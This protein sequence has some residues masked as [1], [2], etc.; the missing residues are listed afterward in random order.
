MHKLRKDA[1]WYT[2]WRKEYGA[3][4]WSSRSTLQGSN[5][6]LS[7]KNQD[8]LDS[9][10]DQWFGC[11]RK[12]KPKT[13]TQLGLVDDH[14]INILWFRP[15]KLLELKNNL[16]VFFSQ[17]IQFLE[18]KGKKDGSLKPSSILYNGPYYLKSLTNLVEWSEV[19]RLYD[20]E[21]VYISVPNPT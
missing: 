20:H 16:W 18:I 3:V 15:E 4:F 5:T 2:E 21:N 12:G 1:K 14:T 11:L 19:K 7:H 17:L 8:A 10:F 13:L 6:R 9:K